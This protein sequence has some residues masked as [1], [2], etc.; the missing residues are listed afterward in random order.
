MFAEELALRNL[1]DSL[2]IVNLIRLVLYLK[3]FADCQTL[4]LLEMKWE[5]LRD[6]LWSTE[7]IQSVNNRE[8]LDVLL[9]GFSV[10]SA[11]Q[12]LTMPEEAKKNICELEYFGIRELEITSNSAA[13]TSLMFSYLS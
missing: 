13:V 1:I 8:D 7:P 3:E 6:I 4:K 5:C 2:E 11:K 10:M 12:N 9:E